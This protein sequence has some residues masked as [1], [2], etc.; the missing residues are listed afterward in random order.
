LAESR[1][2]L[3]FGV[4]N[5]ET[6]DIAFLGDF[7]GEDEDAS[8]LPFV[9]PAGQL[10]DKMIAAMGYTRGDVYTANVIACRPLDGRQPHKKEVEAC[11]PVWRAQMIAVAPKTIVCLG[12]T[13]AHAVLETA[14]PVSKLRGAWHAW[15]GIPVRV[16]YHPA[17]LLREEKAKPDAWSDLQAVLGKLKELRGA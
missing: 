6:P 12:A 1:K 5:S 13:A 4:G 2:N 8:G 14:E 15:N 9:G 3:V 16:T 7:P 11:A 10:L 17:Y